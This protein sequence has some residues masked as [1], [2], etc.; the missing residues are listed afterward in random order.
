MSAAPIDAVITWV[1]GSDPDHARRRAH[2]L[3]KT[4]VSTSGGHQRRWADSDEISICLASLE[5]HAPWLRRIW[6]VTDRQQPSLTAVSRAFARRI[7][8]VDHTVIFQGYE[9][10]LPTYNSLSIGL[11]LWRI[12]K[13]AEQFIYF[14][15]DTFLVRRT[16]PE[17][18]F[19]EGKPVL[20]G[21]FERFATGRQHLH[22]QNREEG[23]RLAGNSGTEYFSR[24][25]VAMSFNRSMLEGHFAAHPLQLREHA[26]PR[27]REPWQGAVSAIHATLA[28]NAN[29]YVMQTEQDWHVVHVKTCKKGTPARI[30]RALRAYAR[31]PQIKLGCVNDVEAA[32]AK[33]P[34]LID[35]LERYIGLRY[36]PA[37]LLRTAPARIARWGRLLAQK[38][39]R[40]LGR[41]A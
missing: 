1:D 37:H 4:I 21:R 10:L 27:F 32:S 17:D 3:G 35:T 20:R 41:G 7:H 16:A 19:V 33:V 14:N 13:L 8:V 26:A 2:A 9:D 11:M 36:P 22:Q 31:R 30:R 25:H 5:L 40:R 24:A 39:E 6:I 29:R 18:F 34:R 12:P 38:V 23:A 15:D 28:L